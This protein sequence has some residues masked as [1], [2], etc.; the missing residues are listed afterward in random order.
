[1]EAKGISHHRSHTLYIMVVLN[2][3]LI[4]R[5]RRQIFGN[6]RTQAVNS[7]HNTTIYTSCE[8][9]IVPWKEHEEKLIILKGNFM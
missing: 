4:N 6:G 7:L 1:M 5:G 9:K 3:S 8:P 2:W